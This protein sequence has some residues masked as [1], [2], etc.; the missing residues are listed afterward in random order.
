M[1]KKAKKLF[2]LIAVLSLIFTLVPALGVGAQEEA[3]P[4]LV[5]TASPN[6]VFLGADATITLSLTDGTGSPV[7]GGI[8]AII[9]V[10]GLG[11]ATVT[12][13]ATDG[14][15]VV[16]IPQSKLAE[17]TFEGSVM[18]SGYQKGVFTLQVA[19]KQLVAAPTSATITFG[20]KVPLAITLK[21]ETGSVVPQGVEALLSLPKGSV[22]ARVGADGVADFTLTPDQ[23]MVGNCT[24][25]LSVEG[26]ADA[27][28]TLN[29]VPGTLL[30]DPANFDVSFAKTVTLAF[31]VLEESS[32]T[33][34]PEGTPITFAL[35]DFVKTVTL[36]KDGT[37]TITLD[38]EQLK[39]GETL[40]PT[41][42]VEGYN[43]VKLPI[44]V[45]E[46]LLKLD[47]AELTVSGKQDVT[48]T[49][50]L[51]DSASMD[52][53]YMLKDEQL[54]ATFTFGPIS[55]TAAVGKNSKVTF[56][57]T[58]SVFEE[59]G[60]GT[61][62]SA[63]MLYGFASAPFKFSITDLPQKEQPQ[64]PEEPTASGTVIAFT[65]G[66]NTFI[67]NGETKQLDVAPYIADGRTMVPLRALCEALGLTVN[68]DFTKPDEKKV[69][70]SG[71]ED[72][73]LTVGSKTAL[74]GG[75]AASLDAA[76]VIVS[77]RTMVPVRFLAEALGFAVDYSDG[78]VTLTQQP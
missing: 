49:V 51:M 12:N 31:G 45:K 23:L 52:V 17:G 44:N 5:V 35:D 8:S 63:V 59:L 38:P 21:S 70:I 14:S 56:T 69:T 66:S 71:A 64:E 65:V 77:G 11:F 55:A 13:S 62:D 43:A 22:V 28:I 29:I 2:S 58:A 30:T 32:S 24:A 3:L 37:A 15:I 36:G 60:G 26:Y 75:E 61:F 42:K 9:S 68:Y 57:L 72:I 7:A 54:V 34:L 4:S 10:D 33:A 74:I 39:V 47:P 18:V 41:L 78:V 1:V 16:V 48:F 50:T 73:V 6:A 76:P 40:E 67:F 53:P 25:I 27:V 46:G 19:G 20:Q